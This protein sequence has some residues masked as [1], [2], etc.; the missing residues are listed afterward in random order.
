M[1]SI[2]YCR[3]SIKLKYDKILDKN[4]NSDIIF[5]ELILVHNLK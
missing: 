2:F 5:Q 1:I 4:D 3:L